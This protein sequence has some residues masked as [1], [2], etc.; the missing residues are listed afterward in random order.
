MHA[1]AGICVG[2]TRFGLEKN[3]MKASNT[4]GCFPQPNYNQKYGE[5]HAH[6]LRSSSAQKTSRSESEL[7]FS[8]SVTCDSCLSVIVRRFAALKRHV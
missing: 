7:F 6:V 8:L 2:A 3:L 5:N 1:F 4:F